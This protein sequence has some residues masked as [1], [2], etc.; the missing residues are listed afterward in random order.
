[1]SIMP[2]RLLNRSL[3]IWSLILSSAILNG[4]LREVLLIPHLPIF[5]AMFFSGLLLC[6]LI[7]LITWLS[8]P[9]FGKHAAR[10]FWC[11]GVEWLLL[12]LAFEWSF[13]LFVQH[14]TWQ[15]LLQAYVFKDANLWPV[16]LVVTL[17]APIVVARWRQ[18]I[19]NGSAL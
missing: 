1:M 15:T 18:H 10:T 19:V 7:V 5:A 17:C 12:T 2:R 6:T 9:W 11:L 3:L 16:V 13:G 8:M 4:A 14:Y